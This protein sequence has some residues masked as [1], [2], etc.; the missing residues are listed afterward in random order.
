MPFARVAAGHYE[1][2]GVGDGRKVCINLYSEPNEN[3]PNR[4]MRHI[5]RPGSQDRD[6]GNVLTSVPRGI[7]Q[8]DGHA[9]GKI[10]VVDGVTVRTYDAASA[11]WGT[12]TGSKHVSV[13][14]STLSGGERY[15][16]GR[17]CA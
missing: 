11:T 8:V 17:P 9:G 3:D 7:G 13:E 14:G 2:D 12:L 10:L 15:S 4:P 16:C 1:S 6:T 5:V